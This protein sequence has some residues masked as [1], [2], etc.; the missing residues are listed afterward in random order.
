MKQIKHA[1]QK[2]LSLV[3]LMVAMT[4][5][6]ILILGV[7][8]VF[9]NSKQTYSTNE[10]LSR[11]QESGRFALQFIVPD[12]RNAASAISCRGNIKIHHTEENKI[13]PEDFATGLKGFS[14]E[15]NKHG[16]SEAILLTS[17]DIIGS[18]EIKSGWKKENENLDI[19]ESEENKLKAE[20]KK[21]A[22]PYGT[23]VFVS[24]GANCDIFEQ[25]EGKSDDEDEDEGNYK[26]KR[27][28]HVG[29]P[30]QGTYSGKVDFMQ[31]K[32]KKYLTR[33]SNKKPMLAREVS[34]LG[35]N[36][37]VI[38]DLVEG[39]ERI[40]IRYGITKT[41]ERK[42]SEYVNLSEVTDWDKVLSLRVSLLAVSPEKNLTKENVT[43]RFAGDDLTIPDG[44][45][46][47]VFTTT[48]GI[49]N[50]LP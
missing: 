12:I 19:T 31:I 3:E 6:S 22:I 44:R 1:S 37:K 10:A 7:I 17:S 5:G 9:L 23:V 21:S 45:L 11:L 38:E 47:Q 26:I 24:D 33:V 43:V 28:S 15:N 29:G 32:S 40:S 46:A 20:G 16:T 25:I 36:S 4:I 34:S 18:F 48:I 27:S 42:V 41:Q 50:R 39:I 30:W 2:G 8:Q 35:K 13:S 14:S 49:R